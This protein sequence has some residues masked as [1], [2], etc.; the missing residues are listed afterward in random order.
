MFAYLCSDGQESQDGGSQKDDASEDDLD[1]KRSSKIPMVFSMGRKSPKI[2]G[3]PNP[4][5]LDTASNTSTSDDE[6]L[7]EKPRKTKRLSLK[8]KEAAHGHRAFENP[9]YGSGTDFEMED[10][11]DVPAINIDKTDNDAVDS[12]KELAENTR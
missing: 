5:T 2:S 12:K 1:A 4:S 10:R 9:V 6:E 3:I 7:K 8:K 11:K